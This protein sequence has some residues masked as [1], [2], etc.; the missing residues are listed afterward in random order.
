MQVYTS[1]ISACSR[2]ILK[3]SPDNRRL[4]LVLLERARGVLAEMRNSGLRPDAFL[5]NALI[6]AAGRAGQVQGAFQTLEDMQ[7]RP[8]PLVHSPGLFPTPYSVCT[9]SDRAVPENTV[10]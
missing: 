2:E 1:L 5:Y 9:C 7:V 10:L 8:P 3:I 4:Q 6:T